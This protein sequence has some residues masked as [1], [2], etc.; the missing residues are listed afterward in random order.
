MKKQGRKKVTMVNVMGIA[1][2]AVI[3]ATLIITN[4]VYNRV[5]ADITGDEGMQAYKGY[6][7]HYAFIADD[8]ERSFWQEVYEGAKGRG[9]ETGVYLEAFRMAT[10]AKI[11]PY[12]PG[13]IA[14]C[15][16]VY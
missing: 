5:Q 3:L 15:I 11:N 6:I 7:R 9:E 4:L 13:H 1:G 16:Q 2:F 10:S 12:V 14:N 8:I